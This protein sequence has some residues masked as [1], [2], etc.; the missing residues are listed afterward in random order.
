MHSSNSQVGS[1]ILAAGASRGGVGHVFR[2]V[3][4][5]LRER[6][7]AVDV[8]DIPVGRAPALKAIATAYATRRAIARAATLHIEFGSNDTEAIWFALTALLMR[9]DCVVV[10]H[11]Y[12]DLAHF[13]AV[14]LLP[15]EQ[16]W[17]MAIGL[18]V[19]SPLLDRT[20]IRL[21]V[22]RPGAVVVFGAEARAHVLAAGA[23]HVEVVTHGGDLPAAAAP[24]PS[25]G[26]SVLFAGFIGPSKGVDT[27]LAA[28]ER[29]N[30][31][32]S[33]PLVLAGDPGPANYVWK[34]GLEQ[35]Y[36]KLP[37]P[38][39]F[40]GPVPDEGRFQDLINHAAVVV[41]PY[42]FSSPASGILVRAMTAGRP[43][44]ATPVPAARASIV[45]GGNGILVPIDDAAALATAILTLANSPA[46]RD[47]LGRAASL[48]ARTR[49][50]WEKHVDGLER[51]YRAARRGANSG[52]PRQRALLPRS[53]RA[54]R[55][56]GRRCG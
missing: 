13:P 3:V 8:V 23:R 1:P 27:L 53:H 22:R 56:S 4:L 46:E 5:E 39:R 6:G 34:T 18:R 2:R 14:G 49:F 30:E 36:A 15:T 41:L 33:L 11:D 21:I 12:P 7:Y 47:R 26:E 52:K 19:L 43:V 55:V 32:V 16:R 10:I 54:S 35:R 45:P 50:T 37:N 28:W 51:A 17:S 29:V 9:R 31:E 40:L 25:S 44:I 42:R 38:P 24:P 48:T 20:L